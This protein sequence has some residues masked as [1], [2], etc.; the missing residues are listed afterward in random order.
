[1]KLTALLMTTGRTGFEVHAIG[2]AD[3]KKTVAKGKVGNR[4]NI[5]ADNEHDAVYEVYGDQIEES[6]GTDGL[7]YAT[8]EE[9]ITGHAPDVTFNPCCKL[10]WGNPEPAKS[11]ADR[12]VKAAVQRGRAARNGQPAES[13]RDK[14]QGSGNRETPKASA[15]QTAKRELATLVAEAAAAMVFE[16]AETAGISQEDAA[17]AIA[18]WLHHLPVDRDRWVAAGLPKPD[19]SDWR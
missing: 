17:K 1:V 13:P 15:K 10:Q 19:R 11:T 5:S 7:Q 9:A 12:N 6:Y 16:H 18:H 4:F 8:L 2:C 14:A 3:I